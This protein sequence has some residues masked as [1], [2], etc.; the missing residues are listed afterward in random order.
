MSKINCYYFAKRLLNLFPAHIRE[1]VE[2]L[3][4]DA[5]FLGS[6]GAEIFSVSPKLK[7]AI[8]SQ[9]P[10]KYFENIAR[11]VY[12]TGSK[13]QQ[14]YMFGLVANYLI[15]SRLNPFICSFHE[16]GVIR[17]KKEE[18]EKSENVE[19]AISVNPDSLDSTNANS[20]IVDNGDST[21]IND[22]STTEKDVAM[23][24]EESV[25][26]EENAEKDAKNKEIVE[27]LD[28]IIDVIAVSN[29]A[30]QQIIPPREEEVY[31][32]KKGFFE[33]DEIDENVSYYAYSTFSEKTKAELAKFQVCEVVLND[34]LQL[35]EE[36]ISYVIGFKINSLVLRHAIALVKT[37]EPN[38]DK[39]EEFDFCNTQ[40]NNW[41]TV[42]NG[43]WITD[44]SLEELFCKLDDIGV[45]F[46][47]GYSK[48]LFYGTA[49]DENAYKLSIRGVL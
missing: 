18:V 38:H 48:R 8:E 23:T 25:D 21:S 39:Y 4:P 41:F 36:R 42:R 22:V 9:D 37:P 20:D 17:F 10:Y 30:Q 43:K 44:M 6:F 34:I 15:S 14:A 13:A 11:Y 19:S 29:K 40:K 32:G 45:K 5:Y 26:A 1:L 49:L 7:N 3:Y 12:Q 24:S 47:L 46:V 16:S 2:K 33:L 31:I 28:K 27:E 35:Y